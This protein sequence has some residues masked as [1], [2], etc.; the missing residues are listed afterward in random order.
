MTGPIDQS[1]FILDWNGKVIVDE[2]YRYENLEFELDR[3]CAK[4]GLERGEQTPWRHKS[5][6]RPYQEYYSSDVRNTVARLFARD[7]ERFGY[8]F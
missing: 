1:R 3:L 5:E 7:I 2:I 6:R 4:L 8:T